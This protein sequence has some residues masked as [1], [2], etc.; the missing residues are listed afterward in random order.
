MINFNNLD[1]PIHFNIIQYLHTNNVLKVE[2]VR[3]WNMVDK[4]LCRN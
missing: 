3:Y 1:V 2:I 4:A